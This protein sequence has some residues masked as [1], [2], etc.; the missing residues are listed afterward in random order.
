M[1]IIWRRYIPPKLSFILWLAL[2][3]RLNT[4]DRWVRETEDMQC[5]FCKRSA[6]IASHLFFSCTF[7]SSI[8][9][10]VRSW[11][12]IRRSMSTL[13]SAIKWIK[14]DYGSAF[15]KSK[16]VV[17]A[18]AATIYNIWNA[19]NKVIFAGK[20]V[21]SSETLNSF[22]TL[23]YTVLSSFYPGDGLLF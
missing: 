22:K 13:H 7:V 14:K 12:N 19:R 17:L 1:T 18:F 10:R 16:D 20:Q 23:V 3:G 8:W 9:S 4:K 21:S 5:A 2:S 11:L 15:I 6:E